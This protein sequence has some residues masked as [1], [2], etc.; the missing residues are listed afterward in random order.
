MLIDRSAETKKLLSSLGL[1]ESIVDGLNERNPSRGIPYH[2]N[3]HMYQVALTTAEILARSGVSLNEMRH[4][5]VAA[6]YHDADYEV[7]LSEPGNIQ[8]A[9]A[10]FLA[11]SK[12]LQLNTLIGEQRVCNL[13]RATNF[14]ERIPCGDN[15]VKALLDADLLCST[16]SKDKKGLMESLK[17]ENPQIIVNPNFPPLEMLLTEVGRNIK[18][19]GETLAITASGALAEAV[20]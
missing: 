3:Q 7:G 1:P 11:E 14:D 2:N 15:K 10:F 18:K 19:N 17:L 13:I 16:F 20:P 12:T 9:I 8:R 4:P 5:V 6:L